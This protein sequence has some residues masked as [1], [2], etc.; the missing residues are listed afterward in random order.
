MGKVTIIA[1]AG[2]NHNGKLEIAEK[3]VDVAADAGADMVKFQ[4]FRA[5]H[6]LSKYA[7]KAD[8]QKKFTDPDESQLEMIRKLELSYEDFRILFE[9]CQ[10]KEIGFLSTPADFESINFLA[11]LG[12]DTIKIAS[13]EITNLPL[14]RKIG[15]LGRKIIMSTGM[16]N[17]AEIETALDILVQSGTEKCDITVLQCHTDYPTKMEDVNLKA[18]ITLRKA[19][20]VRVG[21]S[22]HTIGV[23]IPIAAVALGAKVIEKHF[24]LD[25]SMEGPDHHASLD[26]DQLKEMVVAIRNVKRALGDGIKKPTVSE[27]KIKDIVR[28]SIVA[29]AHIRKGELFTE[30]NLLV[31]RPGTGLSPMLWDHVIGKR[32]PKDFRDDSPIEL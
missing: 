1:E 23:T 14:L 16:A 5:D 26:P 4:T 17:L 6:V 22:D 25:R 20:N 29:S 28:R 15:I 7:P 27:L 18:M 31:K 9:C 21:Y 2:V 19:F 3:M 13:G 30:K 8:Y 24:T 11:H 10:K 12:I 32:A